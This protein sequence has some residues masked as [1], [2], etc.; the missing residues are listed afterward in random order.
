MYYKVEKSAYVAHKHFIYLYFQTMNGSYKGSLTVNIIRYFIRCILFSCLLFTNSV[1]AEWHKTTKYSCSDP[2]ALSTFLSSVGWFS[3]TPYLKFESPHQGYI[4]AD[5]SSSTL[6]E[7]PDVFSAFRVFEKVNLDK[8]K[9]DRLKISIEASSSNMDVSLFVQNLPSLAGYFISNTS[10]AVIG[11]MFTYLF[12][13]IGSQKIQ[14]SQLI[15]LIAAGGKLEHQ[16]RV[17]SEEGKY[18]YS[19][20]YL[21]RVNVGSEER[22]ILIS[23][24]T[25]P[26]N[27]AIRGFV[28]NAGVNDK[29]IVLENGKWFFEN[30]SGGGR[31]EGYLVKKSEDKTYIYFEAKE[32]FSTFY[33]NYRINKFG[34]AF[35][36][37]ES[38]DWVTFYAKTSPF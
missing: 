22:V 7:D 24:C 17:V 37:K 23:A 3:K 14:R 11:S 9:S 4:Y 10:S 16:T 20:I 32:E 29:R 21:Y 2:Y 35:Q 30:L 25:Y 19:S 5:I 8:K 12:D 13:N 38:N 18:F 31:Q 6:I 1:M 33:S 36:G 15:P 28:T 27:I 34:G 26:A